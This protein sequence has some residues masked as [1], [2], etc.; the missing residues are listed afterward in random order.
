MHS[1]LYRF[2]MQRRLC[3]CVKINFKQ[4]QVLNKVLREAERYG[5]TIQW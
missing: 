1:E 3:D 2:L 4:K 5:Y